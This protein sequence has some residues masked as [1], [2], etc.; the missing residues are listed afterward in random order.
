VIRLR[1]DPH[2][3]S[4]VIENEPYAGI[5]DRSRDGGEVVRDRRSLAPLKILHCRKPNMRSAREFLL[6]PP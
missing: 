6:R 1:R 5:L 4:R 3:V 2:G